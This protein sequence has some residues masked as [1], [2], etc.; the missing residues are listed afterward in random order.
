[1]NPQYVIISSVMLIV[2]LYITFFSVK[3]FTP[4]E[5]ENIFSH[6]YTYEGFDL[7]PSTN[8]YNMNSN[9][10][11]DANK[12]VLLK[13][14]DNAECKKVFGLDGLFCSP[15]AKSEKVDI[16]SDVKGDS[17]CYGNSSG[18]SNSKGGLCLDANQLNLLRTRGGNQSGAQAEIGH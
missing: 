13:N 18:L 5:E 4:Y 10:K 1:M 6:M 2:I 16:F 12:S 7:I 3:P 14:A 17:T 9:G 8:E 11:D 15:N